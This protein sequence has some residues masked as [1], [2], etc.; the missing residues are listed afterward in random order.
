MSISI[1]EINK[2]SKKIKN[3]LKLYMLFIQLNKKSYTIE[4]I[5]YTAKKLIKTNKN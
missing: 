1:K 4:Y 3:N 5:S 2:K